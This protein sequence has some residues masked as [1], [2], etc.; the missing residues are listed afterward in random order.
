VTPRK[1]FVAFVVL[2]SGLCGLGAANGCAGGTGSQRFSFEARVGGSGPATTETHT[3]TNQ[4]GWVISLHRANVTL[5]PVYLNVIPPLSDSRASV[6]DL[7]VRPAWAH[8]DGHLDSGR[9]VGE[10]LS[11][12]TFDA[13][14]GELATFPSRGTITQEEVRTAELW[15]Y[16][17]PKVPVDALDPETVALDVAGS[18]TR[19]DESVRF[20]GHLELNDDWISEQTQGTR[21]NQSIAA[22]R[23]VRGVPA[24]FFPTEGGWLEIRFDVTRLFRG[25]DFSSLEHNKTD[26][27]GTKVLEQRQTTA[28]NRDQVTTNLFQGLR[29]TNG[30]YS[31]RWADP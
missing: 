7:F 31:V 6:W 9:M 1:I 16:P 21:G 19:G 4:K 11:Q 20:R 23:K 2:S 25:A 14:S 17:P 12:V 13:L 15:F 26:A 5:G 30:T 18:A 22:I 3:F 10:V 29:E 28:V 24:P 8:G 27:D